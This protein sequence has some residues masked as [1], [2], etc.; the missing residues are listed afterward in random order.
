MSSPW[1]I[2]PVSLLLQTLGTL[3]NVLVRIPTA[4]GR[5]VAVISGFCRGN[6]KALFYII[7]EF[8]LTGFVLKTFAELKLQGYAAVFWYMVLIILP[9]KT[10]YKKFKAY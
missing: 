1:Y 4:A 10:L 5:K 7:F 9:S 6:F 8:W 2:G 3:E